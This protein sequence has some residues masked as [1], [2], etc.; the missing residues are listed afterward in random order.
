[1]S[2]KCIINLSNS[3]NWYLKGQARL[4]DSLKGK[5]DGDILTYTNESEVGSPLHDEN[6]YAFKPYCFYDALNKGYE[7]ILWLDSSVWA[8]KDLQPIF[9]ILENEKYFMLDSGHYID[10][11]IN[12]NCLN[13]FDLKMDDLQGQRLFVAGLFGLN[14]KDDTC[15]DF[16]SKWKLA[17]DNGAFKGSWKDHRHDMTCGSVILNRLGM[18]LKVA[19]YYSSY[20]GQIFGEPKETSFFYLQGM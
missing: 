12:E 2:K 1:M 9:D 16:L 5:F 6:P 7:K 15:I 19:E 8:V 3:K 18:E 4:V 11:W 14:L 13:Y 17:A 10:R 20:I